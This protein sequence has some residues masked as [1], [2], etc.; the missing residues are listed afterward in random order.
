MIEFLVEQFYQ[1]VPDDIYEN[2]F[3]FL[4]DILIYEKLIL[5]VFLI[6]I[7]KKILLLYQ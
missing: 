2:D 1:L 3:I 4:D 7:E 6:L 5:E